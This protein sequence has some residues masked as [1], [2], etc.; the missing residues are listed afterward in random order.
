MNLDFTTKVKSILFL[1]LFLTKLQAATCVTDICKVNASTT[2]TI[3]KFSVC[4]NIINASAKDIMAPSKTAGEWSAFLAHLPASVSS[5]N[6]ATSCTCPDASVVTLGAACSG[7]AICA[8]TYVG[9]KYLVTPGGCTNSATPT[10]AG[11]SDTV[12][13]TWNDG[14]TNWSTTGAESVSV[15]SAASTVLGNVNQAAIVAIVG[16]GNGAPHYA[17]K[18]C[19]DMSYG[20]YT[21]WYL[22]SKSELVYL[23]CNSNRSGNRAAG[24]PQEQT[25]CAGTM[26]G[27]TTVLTGFIADDYWSST[28]GQYDNKAWMMSFSDG[29][30]FGGAN[31]DNAAYLRCVRRY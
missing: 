4:K 12:S 16:A 19:D 23:F 8:G 11:G 14:S 28:E 21:D 9:N 22:P 29:S 7:G 5:T 17:A 31:K 24:N 2:V 30:E 18:F 3:D 1:F 6:C 26:G 10:C 25:N 15:D 27:P 13:K 20:G